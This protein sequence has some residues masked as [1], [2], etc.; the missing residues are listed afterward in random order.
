MVSPRAE[1]PRSRMA[2]SNLPLEAPPAGPPAATRRIFAVLVAGLALGSFG[3]A[4]L[5]QRLRIEGSAFP[6]FWAPAGLFLAALLLFPASRWAVLALAVGVAQIASDVLVHRQTA[7][8]SLASFAVHTLGAL[9]A[10]AVLRRFRAGPFRLDTLRAVWLFLGCST[11][12]SALVAAPAHALLA[13]IFW[14]ADFSQS[15]GYWFLANLAGI[16]LT[17][18]TLLALAA[19]DLPPLR[20]WPRLRIAEALLLFGSLTGVAFW[21]FTSPPAFFSLPSLLTL[22]AIWAVLRFGAAGSGVAMLIIGLTAIF[23]TVGA[24][25]P[26]ARPDR[27]V[28]ESVMRLLIYLGTWSGVFHIVAAILAERARA[29]TALARLNQDLERRVAE[30]TRSLTAAGEALRESEERFRLAAAA[31]E[32]GAYDHH[33]RTGFLHWS[34]EMKTIFGID[35]AAEVEGTEVLAI[36]HPEDRE[37]VRVAYERSLDPAGHGA[38]EVEHRILR[39]D[40]GERWVRVSGRTMFEENG[41]GRVPLRALGTCT[42]ITE[43]KQAEQA[44]RESENRLALAVKAGHSGTYDWDIRKNV[45]HWSEDL[46]ALYGIAPE[47]FTGRY[48]DWAASLHPED[49]QAAEAAVRN[50]FVTGQ[51]TAQ[52][53]IRRRDTG[54]I[55]WMEAR[56]TL[57]TD[58]E[59]KPARLLGINVDITDQKRVEEALRESEQRLK[60][61]L[62]AVNVGVWSIDLQ[63][64]VFTAS[65]ECRRN[66]GVGVGEEFARYEHVRAR[67]HPDDRAHEAAAA[68]SARGGDGEYDA[69][70]RVVWPDKSVHWILARGQASPGTDGAAVRLSGIALDITERK[71]VEQALKESESKLRSYYEAAPLFMGLVELEGD[72]LRHLYDNPASCRFFGVPSGGTVGRRASELGANQEV[73]GL[74]LKYYR[75]SEE[76]GEPVHFDISS[77]SP[78]GDRWLSITV[79]PLPAQEAQRRR[80]SYVAEDVTSRRRTETALRQH[81]AR[82]A[83]LLELTRTIISKRAEEAALG[84]AIFQR[85]SGVIDAD[86]GL[87]HRLDAASGKLRLVA[88][89]GLSPEDHALAQELELSSC[90]CGAAATA[91][92]PLLADAAEI[93]GDARGAFVR[94]LGARAYACHPLHASDGRVLGTLSFASTRRERFEPEEISFLQ[95]LCHYV[96]MAW[97][98]GAAE[99]AMLEAKEAAESASRAKDEF[100]AAL[101]HELR[102]PLNPVLLLAS[103]LQN[104]P[105]LSPELRSDLATIRRNVELEARLIDDLLDLTRITRGKVS[106]QLRPTD[107][108]RVLSETIEILGADVAAK[109][110]RLNVERMAGRPTVLADPVRLQQVL[111]N[112]LRNAIKF[113]S[114]EG[115]VTV[116]T[117]EEPAGR[118]HLEVSDTGEGIPAVH[119]A[120]IFDTFNQGAGGHRF[121]GLGLGL[122]IARSIVELHGGV[123]R[124]QS[125]GL[126]QGSTFSIELPL[127]TE[128]DAAPPP[129]A[130]QPSS[131][132]AL[133]SL[134]I[135][136]VEDHEP[137]RAALTRLLQRR[138]HA[139]TAA[140]DLASARSLAA[141]QPFDLLISDLGLPDG[142]GSDLM[143]DFRAEGGPPG[144]ALSGYGMDEDLQR[145][146]GAGFFA[147]LVKPVDVEALDR[148]LSEWALSETALT[149]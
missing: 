11:L 27:S 81:A 58:E 88:G 142:D 104:Q 131:A 42:D 52:F 40:G 63:T 127:L 22:W 30:R 14:G 77:P 62:E 122:A 112:V 54:E 132:Q 86:L 60:F 37:R 5:S 92:V 115:L 133:P 111:W 45:N 126:G 119:L 138:R 79:T 144:I 55:R 64:G 89:F 107:V 105:D 32:F 87:N 67:I 100:L 1:R 21:M 18:P 73:I 103:E 134:R 36:L 7:G 49:R 114:S 93:D 4:E 106:L 59:G 71:E 47:E 8:V 97:E 149:R 117:R 98:R 56:G 76:R 72:D 140:G 136:L 123:I 135:L 46:L 34:P 17:T 53:R 28:T 41:E 94:R 139:V 95:T 9:A 125:A 19:H 118:L 121:G 108:H 33:L 25:G 16:W 50:S 38:L 10:A 141:S 29:V 3:A 13:R 70:Y 148:T 24:L 74:W 44:L 90:F 110:L 109:Q 83:A 80:F 116:R 68:A 2:E 6:S 39:R 65:S 147:H 31:A 82:Q 137:T 61:V 66:F 143:R 26:F 146:R 51:F 102:T 84:E 130:P 129:R 57:L 113:T 85:V 43:Q 35:P 128:A 69:E 120:T 48:E 96:A 145:S 101:S 78:T 91:G 20:A 99:A 75:L 15:W 23:S 12:V 124:A